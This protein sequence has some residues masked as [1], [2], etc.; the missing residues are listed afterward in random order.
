[1][2]HAEVWEDILLLASAPVSFPSGVSSS[3]PSGPKPVHWFVSS[4]IPSPTFSSSSSLLS[5]SSS[6]SIS[7]SN[8]SSSSASLSSLSS[9]SDSDSSVSAVFSYLI[10]YKPLRGKCGYDHVP[11]HQIHHHLL[12]P[13]RPGQQ[14]GLMGMLSANTH[15]EPTK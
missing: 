5:S 3:D 11:K 7:S 10:V 6:S 8:S 12:N 9:S 14:E 1:M 13:S 4:S 2:C 15:I